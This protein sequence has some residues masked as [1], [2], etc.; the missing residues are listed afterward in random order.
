MTI[1]S[2][3]YGLVT[4]DASIPKTLPINF[5]HS[6]NIK[7]QFALNKDK[8]DYSSINTLLV[9]NLPL[10][11]GP[12][13][14]PVLGVID[15]E[16]LFSPP[17]HNDG[18]LQQ[19]DLAEEMFKKVKELNLMGLQEEIYAKIPTQDK[20]PN[21]AYQRLVHGRAELLALN[22]KEIAYRTVATGIIPY[23]PGIPM[24]LSGENI[25]PAD[26]PHLKYLCALQEWDKEF[27]G[28]SHDIHGV[29]NKDGKY[30]I[31]CLI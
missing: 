6:F 27:K 20:T 21:Q 13:Q 24:L 4:I 12:H 5:A 26:G 22:D 23:P 3:T 14:K 2:L 7:Q 10:P 30:H 16:L 9:L 17:K 18:D 11:V 19:I 8:W 1:D 15:K 28:F 31:Y 29:E 25:G